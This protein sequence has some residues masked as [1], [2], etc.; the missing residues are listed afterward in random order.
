MRWASALAVVVVIAAGCGASGDS[1]DEGEGTGSS[2]TVASSDGG[3]EMFGSLASPCGDGSATVAKG[4]AGKGTDKLYIGVNSDKGSNVRP[5]L[6][7]E[8]WDASNAFADW[9]NAQGGIQGLQ[10]EIID[11]DGKLTEVANFIPTACNDTFAMVGGGSTLD[12]VLVT[13][14]DNIRKCGLLSVPGFTVTQAF[15]DATDVYVAP[16]PNNA[17]ER[18]TAMLRYVADTYPEEAGDVATAYGDLDTIRF[19]RDQV[20]ATMEAIGKPFGIGEQ[21][22]YAVMGQDFKLISQRM[23]GSGA[24]MGSFIGEPANF[25]LFLKALKE[26]GVDIPIFAESNMYDPAVLE[27]GSNPL[28]DVL[29]RLPYPLFTEASEFPAMQK[30]LDLMEARKK[31]D[32]EAKIAGLGIQ[33]TSAWLLFATAASTCGADGGEI[34]RECVRKEIEAI[35]EWNSGGLHATTNPGENLPV[36]CEL[37]VKIDGDKFA[38]AF[39]EI[40]SAD[41]DENGY[42]CPEDGYIKINVG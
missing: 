8:M 38:R 30:Y 40:G 11:L 18:P 23:K 34:S 2:T 12:D 39:P 20:N 33:S 31:V 42:S 5:G 36:S 17:T 28:G 13:G 21:I 26:D 27:A 22:A 9:C 35:G 4:E 10:I 14:P 29:I 16:L 37:V 15:A 7:R 19:V 32:K 1:T 6:L 25:G 3:A 24:T 41:A